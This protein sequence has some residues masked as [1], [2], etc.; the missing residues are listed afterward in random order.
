NHKSAL[1][2]LDVICSYCKD[3][4]ALG[5]MSGPHSEAEVQNILG[6]HFTSSPLGIVKKSGEPGKFRV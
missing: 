6:G 3:K 4:V 1:D 2:H 5:H